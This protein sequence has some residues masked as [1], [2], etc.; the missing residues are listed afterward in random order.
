MTERRSQPQRREETTRKLLDATIESIMEVGYAATTVR[1]VTERAGVSL[2]ARSHFFPRR[3]DMVIAALDQLCD[4]RLTAARDALADI[5]TDDAA[6]LRA[7]L[8]M[9]WQDYT[10]TS[11]VAGMKLWVAAA[12][13]PELHEHLVTS[14]RKLSEAL[15]SLYMEAVGT[16]LLRIPDI[17]ERLSMVNDLLTGHA[18]RRAFEPLDQ[19]SPSIDWPSL[20][21]QLEHLILG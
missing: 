14:T 4:D 21:G 5:P 7:L 18:F 2:G 13:D 16:D 11:F 8:D 20:R 15:L 9:M 19:P 3:I 12:D 17:G 1:N 6:R 10:G